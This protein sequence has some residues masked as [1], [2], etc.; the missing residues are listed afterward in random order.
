MNKQPVCMVVCLR[1]EACT[2]ACIDMTRT[3]RRARVQSALVSNLYFISQLLYKRFP[4]F[5]L[6]RLLGRWSDMECAA[7]I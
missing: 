4:S 1:P 5:F 2:K 3:H 6:V 7:N